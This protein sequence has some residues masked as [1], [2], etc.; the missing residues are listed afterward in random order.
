M[1]DRQYYFISLMIIIETM[2]PFFMIFEQRKPEA[3]ELVVIAVMV[4]IAILG[5][6]AFF[7]FP[8]VKPI[9]A[10]VAISG[11]CLGAEAGFLCGAMTAF[12]SNFFFGQG[13]WTP[14][15]MFALGLI[16]FLAGIFFKKGWLSKKRLPLCIFGFFSALIVYGLIM[17]TC[18]I[19]TLAFD[20]ST[21]GPLAYYISGFP[22]NMV[23]GISTFFF[24]WVLSKPMIEKLD[25]IKKKYGMME[26]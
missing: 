26:S 13:P 20:T 25:R 17:D 22:V 16:G 15:Q 23:Y 3:R 21:T 10:I 2:I 6:A 12:V 18:T 4:G 1:N 24:L 9:W 8:Y 11:V 14:W 7:M 5:R 19:F